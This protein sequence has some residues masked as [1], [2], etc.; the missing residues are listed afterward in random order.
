MTRAEEDIYTPAAATRILVQSHEN[1]AR[2]MGL[3]DT[4]RHR[5]SVAEAQASVVDDAEEL[6]I[7]MK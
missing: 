6:S 2:L 1:L 3:L 7:H 5:H 4:L